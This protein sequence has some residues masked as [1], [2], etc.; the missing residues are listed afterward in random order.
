MRKISFLTLFF[1]ILSVLVTP[2][3]WAAAPKIGGTCSKVGSFGDTPSARYVCVKSGGKLVW[4]PWSPSTSKSGSGVY[5]PTGKFKAPI[6]I[7]LPVTQ[8]K[9]PS[10]ITFANIQEHISEIPQVA[11]QKFQ[12][13]MT[14]NKAVTIP[15]SIYVGPTTK[16]DI[17]GGTTRIQEL[18]A[19]SARLWSGFS[20]MDFYAVYVYNGADEALTEAKFTS[21]FKAK[22]YDLK[23]AENLAGLLRALAGNCQKGVSPG[24]FTGPLG[25]CNGANSGSYFNSNDAFVHLGQTGTNTNLF[26]A[27]GGVLGHEYIHAVQAGQWIN[28]PF[29]G[30]PTSGDKLCARSE[31]SNKGFA[32]CWINEGI[33]NSVGAMVAMESSENYLKY[34]NSNL[35]YG[36][37]PTTVTDYSQQSLKNYLFNQSSKTCYE[38]GPFYKMGY[39]VGALATEALVAIAG[40]QATMAVYSLGAQGQDFPTA[41]KNVYGISWSDASTILSKVLAAEYAAFGSPPK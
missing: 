32:P 33:P 23:R 25:D 12:S 10:A 2:Q 27:S 26:A 14:A 6:P 7:T 21:D 18:L 28:S 29:C 38:D 31:M 9:D 30:N 16:M 17:V 11:W 1:L 41:F 37:G 22:K 34:R 20:Q 13:V 3:A 5:L 35:P 15:N 8:S 40:P 24:K 19:K 39:T 36:Q 4:G